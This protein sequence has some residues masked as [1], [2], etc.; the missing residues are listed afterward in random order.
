[1][2]A[3]TPAEGI[4]KKNEWGDAKTYHVVCE[5][6]QVDHSH[7]L[8]IEAD[9]TGVTVTIYVEVKSPWW[10]MNRWKQMWSLITKG[11]LQQETIL[12]MSEQTALNYSEI[13][14]KAI[15]DVKT[16]KKS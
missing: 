1:M 10:S 6:G 12:T 16:F 13:L 3:Q 7:N 14:K 8:W 15:Q 11:Y 5:C 4:L 9:E 2:K